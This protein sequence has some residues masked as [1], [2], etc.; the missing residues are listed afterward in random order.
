MPETT[1]TRSTEQQ[2]L[3]ALV[4]IGRTLRACDGLDSCL[5]GI[6]ELTSRMF[7]AE[8]SSIFLY[9][10]ETDELVSRVAEGLDESHEIRFPATKGLAGHVARTGET[11]NIAD[12]YEDPRFNPQSD[13]QTGFRTRAVLA[14]PLFG[15]DRKVIGVLQ[16]LNKIGG[17]RF[18]EEDE[19]LLEAVAGQCAVVLDNARLMNDL[20]T[21]FET[22]IDAAS[23]AI[24]Q[25]DPTTAGHSRRVTRYTL[26][27]AR[28]VH[29]SDAPPFRDRS[30]N[31]KTIRQ[32][33]YAGLL[34]D[35]GKIGVREAVLCKVNKLH[36]G[37]DQAVENRIARA[38]ERRKT[39]FLLDAVKRGDADCDRVREHVEAMDRECEDTIGLVHAMNA[40]GARIEGGEERL[41][42]LFGEGLLTREEFAFLSIGKGNLAD[43]EW[44]EM[45]SHA[46][47]SY[48]VL[49]RITWPE[50]LVE[51]PRIAH[52]HHEK[53][54][55]TGYPL[56][57]KAD[58]IHFDSKMMCVADIYD[59]LT[60]SDRP[61]KKAM[62]HER[63]MAILREEVRRGAL[64][65]DLVE[66]FESA[67]CFRL[68]PEDECRGGI[69]D[70][71][72][73]A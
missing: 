52:G 50:D 49:R 27:L 63:A 67:G 22:F 51:V 61:Y 29:Y 66:L 4:E 15:H 2:R 32:L 33:R 45:K 9:D 69:F 16:V 53:L 59:A 57:L 10:G 21:V 17:G 37:F 41:R 3:I 60:S 39:D 26:N 56:G 23:Q 6:A 40:S 42:R 30:Y 58:E 14:A 54:D 12:A 65:G 34:H 20:D 46:A 70:D 13:R 44:E 31:R 36:P 72:F 73:Q 48:Q 47:K 25:R 43:Y 35:F 11:L 7:G 38:Y 28:A 24:D 62:T 64:D 55:G 19:Q 68:N 8:R 71:E 1:S 18:E 5:C